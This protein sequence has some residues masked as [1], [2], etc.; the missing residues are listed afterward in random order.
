M[1]N[2]ENMDMDAYAEIFRALANPHR[3]RIFANLAD[4][5]T[6]GTRCAE[7]VRVCVGDI[8]GELDLAPST[9]SHHLKELRRAGLI[10]AERSGQTVE[11][12]VDPEILRALSHFFRHFLSDE[13]ALEVA[14]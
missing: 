1:S 13:A 4:C 12:W 9:V 6:P 2:Y 7:D 8:S 10:R 5:C 3:L 11:C 14:C